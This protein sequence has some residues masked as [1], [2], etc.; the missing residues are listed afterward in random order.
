MLTV[1]RCPPILSSLPC[2]NYYYGQHGYCER[3]HFDSVPVKYFGH[4]MPKGKCPPFIVVQSL[5]LMAIIKLQS[6]K[7]N[8]LMAIW[9]RSIYDAH[10]SSRCRCECGLRVAGCGMRWSMMWI[11]CELQSWRWFRAWLIG[12]CNDK[13][14]SYDLWGDNKHSCSCG[15]RTV[16]YF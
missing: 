4:W 11:T 14:R 7:R 2:I 3:L 9:W 8:K 15:E 12:F 6:N 5:K 13:Y 10:K 16:F 1:I